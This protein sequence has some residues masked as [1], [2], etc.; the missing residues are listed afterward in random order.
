MLANNL[1]NSKFSLKNYIN[2]INIIWKYIVII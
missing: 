2:C 1:P